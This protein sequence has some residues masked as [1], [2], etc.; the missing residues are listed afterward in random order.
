[1]RP[2]TSSRRSSWTFDPERGSVRAWLLQIAHFRML[3]ELR[4]RSRQPAIEPDPE[5][6][7]LASVPARDPGPAEA[8]AEEHRR[9]AVH[10]AVDELPPPQR[11]AIRL[12]FLDDLTHDQV[13]AELGL[14]LG[15]AKTRIRAGLQ[16]LRDRLGPQWAALVALGLLVALGVRYRSEHATLERYDRAL[17]MVTAS[18]SVN[19]R[20]GPMPGR[21][22]EMH[23]RYRGRPGVGT[24]VIT[25]SKFPPAPEGRTYQAWARHGATWTSLGTVR[26][27]GDGS[28]RLIAESPALVAL[29]DAL[30]V[31]VEPGSGS[32]GPSGPVVVAWSQ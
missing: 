19:L 12:A 32:T 29:P 21:P 1:M 5:G 17:S 16:K 31:T 10:S 22:E 23:A 8:A 7:V 27:D 9:A 13:A 28:A 25:F 3:N 14:P 4:R 26:P 18:D 11:E 15:T 30:E 6:H 2:K 20:L 24:A